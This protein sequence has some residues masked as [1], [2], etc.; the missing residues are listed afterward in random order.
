MK[1]NKFI[2]YLYVVASIPLFWGNPISTVLCF[3]EDGHIAI[4]ASQNFICYKTRLHA[5]EINYGISAHSTSLSS[6]D[7]CGPC[8]DMPFFFSSLGKYPIVSREFSSLTQPESLNFSFHSPEKLAPRTVHDISS[9]ITIQP[10][11]LAL[12]SFQNTV[13]LI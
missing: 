10:I 9:I 4:E 12:V 7:H 8:V 6:S 3:G 1:R 13:L 2:L 11:I 5:S